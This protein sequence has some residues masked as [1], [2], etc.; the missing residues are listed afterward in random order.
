MNVAQQIDFGPAAVEPPDLIDHART[1]PEA[2]G[3]LYEL[4]YSAIRNYIYRR[5]LNG[6]TADDLTSNT[7]F[8][9]LR[10]LPKYEARAPFRVWLYKIATNEIR[11]HRRSAWFRRIIGIEQAGVD[12]IDRVYFSAPDAHSRIENQERMKHYAALHA[13]LIKVGEPY[14]TA[15]MLRYFEELKYDEIAGVLGKP[16]GTIKSLVRRGIK[17]LARLMKKDATDS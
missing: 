16:S 1:D 4:H 3:E 6:A 14:Q 9:A 15:L 7:F 12:A 8:K 2:F 10:A 17:K 11:A 5:T 13:A